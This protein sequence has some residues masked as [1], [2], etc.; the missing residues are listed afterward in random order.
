MG[1]RPLQ[2][3]LEEDGEYNVGAQW[4]ADCT[5]L[6]RHHDHNDIQCGENVER[7]D[8]MVS[9]EGFDTMIRQLKAVWNFFLRDVNKD[10]NFD[11]VCFDPYGQCRSVALARIVSFCLII[12][13]VQV[14]DVI[15]CSQS[16]WQWQCCKGECTHCTNDPMSVE[17]TAVLMRAYDIWE[18]S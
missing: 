1:M 3:L 8:Q 14:L 9:G 2:M 15:H 16:K 18:R 13:G 6:K 5:P 12:E 17:K 7:L 10:N 11:G 4:R